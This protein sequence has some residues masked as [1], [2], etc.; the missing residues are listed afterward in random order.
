MN[1]TAKTIITNVYKYFEKQSKKTKSSRPPKLSKKTAEATGYSSRTIEGVI[2]AT[3]ALSGAAFES[4]AKRYKTSR[5]RI[6]VNDFEVAAIRRTIHDFYDR[7]EYPTLKKLLSVLITKGLF[8]GHRTTLW[9]LLR[10]IGFRYRKVNDKRYVYEQPRIIAW[11]HKYLRRMMKNR[12]EKRPVVYL[13]ETWVN[14]HDGKAKTWVEKDTTTDG[15]R[16][17]VR[18]PS[19]KGSR[20]IILHAG[21]EKGWVTAQN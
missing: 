3:Q 4:P 12:Q 1:S 7:K 9:K 19:G 5:V 16:G 8:K 15:T 10:K 11:R 20:L 18:K 13:D 2:A 14:S 21:G 6:I 17:G